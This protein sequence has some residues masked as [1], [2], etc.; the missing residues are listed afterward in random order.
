MNIINVCDLNNKDLK[1]CIEVLNKKRLDSKVYFCFENAQSSL[2]NQ[3]FELVVK[4]QLEK[5]D[6]KIK[7][8]NLK[9]S[10][11]SKKTSCSILSLKN[12]CFNK[13]IEIKQTGSIEI[14]LK[15]LPSLIL[16]DLF[17]FILEKHYQCMLN[18]K[19]AHRKLELKASSDIPIKNIREKL[20]AY[21]FL[22]PHHITLKCGEEDLDPYKTLFEYKF[23]FEEKI[24]LS[25]EST[26]IE[27]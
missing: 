14:L 15:S 2:I 1:S 27:N 26:W 5:L 24:N 13:L 20:A 12:L 8:K 22:P 4:K 21:F 7:N 3:L 25:L 11:L 6:T 9:V 17:S 16:N 18:I 19:Y 23:S 10:Q